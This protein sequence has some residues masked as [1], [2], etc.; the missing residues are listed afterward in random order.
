M[1][2]EALSLKMCPPFELDAGKHTESIRSAWRATSSKTTSG[3]SNASSWNVRNREATK[4]LSLD[5]DV[6]AYC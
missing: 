5:R 4:R 1:S 2:S 6:G 3:T